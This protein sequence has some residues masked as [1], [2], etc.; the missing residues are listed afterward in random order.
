MHAGL[1]DMLHDAADHNIVPIAYGVHID[2]Y[3]L[4]QKAIQTYNKQDAVSNASKVQRFAILTSDFQFVGE[5]AELTATL[6]LKRPV[7][8]RKFD[9]VIKGIYAGTAGHDVTPRK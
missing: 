4:I 6:K 2:F 3:R 9:S 1:F 8:M 5:E 7:V